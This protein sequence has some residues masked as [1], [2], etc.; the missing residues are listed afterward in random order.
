MP[1]LANYLKSIDLHN[2]ARA[3]ELK[4]IFKTEVRAAEI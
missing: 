3:A 2:K 4:S 1:V